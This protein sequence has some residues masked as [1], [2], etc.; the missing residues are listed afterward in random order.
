LA[1]GFAPQSVQH[2]R[3]VLGIA[4][5]RAIKW[6]LVARNV[7]ALTTGPKVDRAAVKPLSEEGAQKLLGIVS[8]HRLEALY[9]MAL[10]VAMRRGEILALR[11]NCIDMDA[12]ELRVE[13]SLQRVDGRLQLLPLK[14]KSST[15]PIRLPEQLLAALKRRRARQKEEHLAAGPDWQGNP[16][17]LVFT[18]L[19]GTALE[20]RN[21]V[22]NFKT[23]LAKAELPDAKFHDLR[24]TCATF[25]SRTARIQSRFRLCSG[26][27][28]S[29]RR[30]TYT[31]TSTR[32]R[33]TIPRTGWTAF[34]EQGRR[35][36]EFCHLLSPRPFLDVARNS[37]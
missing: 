34:L 4:L 25:S 11:W 9:V 5:R 17:N 21:V 31:R 15:R 33:S 28:E 22:R 37:P 29:V 12:R 35:P 2:I 24:H 19:R 1:D 7:S 26:T 14:T 20:P 27:A 32:R 13:Q 36:P 23:M 8:G 30:S 18:S 6:N 16:D 10:S 3:T